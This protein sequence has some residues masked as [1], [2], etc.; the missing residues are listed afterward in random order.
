MDINLSQSSCEIITDLEVCSETDNVSSQF[1]EIADQV[2]KINV[3]NESSQSSLQSS[4]SA[5]SSLGFSASSSSLSTEH[6]EPKKLKRKR[7][8]KRQRNTTTAYNPATPFKARYK[9]IKLA[10][11][12]V[13]PKSHIRFDETG[14]M[15]T[16]TSVYNTKPRI[17][18]A[19]AKNF[20]INEDLKERKCQ[21]SSDSLL[22]DIEDENAEAVLAISLRPRII[23]AIVV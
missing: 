1:S 8:R 16:A 7:K 14:E 17:I 19:F 23:K 18:S 21:S 9:R 13:L 5:S 2:D 3:K 22:L 15:D 20:T 6:D 11:Y 10:Q 4:T 12:D